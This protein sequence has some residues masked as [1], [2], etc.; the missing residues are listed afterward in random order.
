MMANKS[1]P[2]NNAPATLPITIPMIAPV[3]S[4]FGGVGVGVGGKVWLTDAPNN[5]P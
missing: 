3:E 1:S 5:S 2:I 4:F